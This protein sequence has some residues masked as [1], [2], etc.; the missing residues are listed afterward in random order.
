MAAAVGLFDAKDCFFVFIL[1]FS[2]KSG[3]R[4]AKAA[5]EPGRLAQP[6]EKRLLRMLAQFPFAVESAAK[7][8]EPYRIIEYLNELAKTFHNFYT[9]HRVVNEDDPE[10]TASRLGLVKGIKTVLANGLNLLGISFPER[11]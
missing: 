4:P 6:E 7:N 10:T 8:L 9:K 3:M 1:G 5:F 2:K 11:M